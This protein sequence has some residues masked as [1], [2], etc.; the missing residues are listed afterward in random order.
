MLILGALDR[1]ESKIYTN[2]PIE[3]ENLKTFASALKNYPIHSSD[4]LLTDL[5]ERLVLAFPF[6]KRYS[7]EIV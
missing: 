3:T 5:R 1:L 7:N 6:R 4:Y 2:S